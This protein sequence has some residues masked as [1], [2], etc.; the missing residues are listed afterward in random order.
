MG[1]RIVD[2]L[3]TFWHSFRMIWDGPSTV[4]HTHEDGNHY[5]MYFFQSW[6]KNQIVHQVLPPLL[7]SSLGIKSCATAAIG[8]FRL[9][10]HTNEFSPW[11]MDN[12]LVWV[13]HWDDSRFTF[14]TGFI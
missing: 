10:E 11:I 6:Q 5:C 14:F 9:T 3:R 12:D 8:D 2:S 4:Q 13:N 1:L 7:I